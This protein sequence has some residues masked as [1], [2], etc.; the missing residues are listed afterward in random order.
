[1]EVSCPRGGNPLGVSSSDVHQVVFRCNG[2]VQFKDRVVPSD[3]VP[4]GG[5]AAEP[6][7]SEPV[8]RGGLFFG[9]RS[10]PSLK[11]AVLTCYEVALKASSV[12]DFI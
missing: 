11:K 6:A 10:L 8:A 3:V 5:G 12:A 7:T 2:D 4:D 9:S 1:M